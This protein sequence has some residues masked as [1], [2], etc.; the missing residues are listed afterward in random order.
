MVVV[1]YITAAPESV[2][3]LTADKKKV[4]EYMSPMEVLHIDLKRNKLRL[5]FFE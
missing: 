4:L 2:K 5:R 3:N 1:N